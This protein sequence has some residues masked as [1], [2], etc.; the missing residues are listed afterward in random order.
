MNNIYAQLTKNRLIAMLFIAASLVLCGN[1]FA[2]NANTKSAYNQTLALALKA[3]EK[4]KSLEAQWTTVPPLLKKAKDAANKK[5]YVRANKY[6]AEA[7][8]HAELGIEQAE[9]Q[10]QRWVNS[11]PR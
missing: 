9:Q 4:A 5:D 8:K 6:A 1:A 7:L 2:G 11:V 10:A 3:D